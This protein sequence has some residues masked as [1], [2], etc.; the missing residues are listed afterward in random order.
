MDIRD[1]RYFC[2]TAELEHVSKAA[3]KLG[4][5]QPYLTKIIGQIEDEFGAELFDKVGRKIKLNND[6]EV[7]YQNAKKSLRMLTISIPKWIL[8]SKST[9]VRY[10]LS[11]TP[12]LIRME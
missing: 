8:S 2:L 11:A 6:G 10:R 1:L 7:F 12:K 5:A 4:I 3:E 9:D